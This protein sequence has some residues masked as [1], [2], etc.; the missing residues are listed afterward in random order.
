M[1]RQRFT[2]EEDAILRR[3]CRKDLLE[4]SDKFDRSYGSVK[5]RFNRVRD[6]GPDGKPEKAK[7]ASTAMAQNQSYSKPRAEFR[8]SRLSLPFARPAW[9]DEPNPVELAMGR[10]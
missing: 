4:L 9:F 1:S 10:R 8:P 5:A 7:S 3:A 6:R 2:P